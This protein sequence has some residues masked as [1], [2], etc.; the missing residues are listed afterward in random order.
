[1]PS[2]YF[3]ET[4]VVVPDDDTPLAGPISILAAIIPRPRCDAY[5]VRG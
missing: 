3:P 4:F 2:T 1:M 5:Y